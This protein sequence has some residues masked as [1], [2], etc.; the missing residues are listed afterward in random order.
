MIRVTFSIP[1]ELKE[2]LDQRPDVNWPEVIKQGLRK[3]LDVLQKLR[4]RG[5]L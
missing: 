1:K 3:R 4:A 2:R 5:E